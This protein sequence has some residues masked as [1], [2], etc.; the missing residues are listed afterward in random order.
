MLVFP[1]S[2][3]KATMNISLAAYLC[4]LLW[5]LFINQSD[6]KSL[7]IYSHSPRPFKSL[8]LIVL[9]EFNNFYVDTFIPKAVDFQKFQVLLLRF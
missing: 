9:I 7:I 3:N 5:T 2:L 8:H 4:Y 1:R 6:L